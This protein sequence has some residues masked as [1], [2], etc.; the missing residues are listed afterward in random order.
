MNDRDWLDKVYRA[1]TVYEDTHGER[2]EILEFIK[3]L[4][5]E[6]GIVHPAERKT[7]DTNNKRHN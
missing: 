7:N 3:W 6:Y 5:K 2:P 1:F 4:Y